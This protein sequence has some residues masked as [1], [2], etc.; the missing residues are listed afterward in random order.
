MSILQ[1]TPG[2]PTPAPEQLANQLRQNCRAT[3]AHLVSSFNE[4]ARL[5]WQSPAATPSQIADALGAD[6]A[7]MFALHAAVGRLLAEVSP[8]SIAAGAA[9]VGQFEVNSDGTVTV[10]D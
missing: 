8:S 6:A 4:N 7:E 1:P 5:F 10:Q 2:A 9:A 3:F